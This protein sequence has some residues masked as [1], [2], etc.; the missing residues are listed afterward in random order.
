MSDATKNSPS[1][2]PDDDRRPVADGDDLVGIVGRDQHQREE[3][4]HVAQRT[5]HRVLETVALRISRSTR[6]ATISVSVS[7]TNVC[8][9]FCS[10]VLQVEVVLDDPVVD[11]NDAPGTVTMGMGVL[12]G[13]PTVRRPA[14]MADA[15]VA[16]E[17]IARR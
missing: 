4:A 13:G 6:C 9:S 5:P 14:R 11:D 1:P 2:R 12:L 3:A 17:R 16:L 7:V 15:V 10:C 8:P